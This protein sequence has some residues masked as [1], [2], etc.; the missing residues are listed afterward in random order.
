MSDRWRKISDCLLR[1]ATKSYTIIDIPSGRIM[2]IDICK[3]EII[4]RGTYLVLLASH[5]LR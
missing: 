4:F 5:Y 3:W 1:E 2:K